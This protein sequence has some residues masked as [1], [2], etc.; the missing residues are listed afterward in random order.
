M[1]NPHL[2][3]CKRSQHF[4]PDSK[5]NSPTVEENPNVVHLDESVLEPISPMQETLS[6]L[7]S[8]HFVPFSR[9]RT[10]IQKAKSVR[11]RLQPSTQ[12]VVQL[13]E[14]T[15]HL[16]DEIKVE[17]INPNSSLL[18]LASLSAEL[19]KDTDQMDI[20]TSEDPLPNVHLNPP[21]T[22]ISPP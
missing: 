13:D 17:E 2:N 21:S 20:P 8:A 6:S 4:H 10:R 14:Q 16:N 12:I 19:L 1:L 15:G 3:I 22:K 5:K 11:R 9:P 18:A 7:V